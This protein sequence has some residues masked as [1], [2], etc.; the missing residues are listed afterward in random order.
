MFCFLS[1][2]E[3]FTVKSCLQLGFSKVKSFEF[4]AQYCALLAGIGTTLATHAK[5]MM[6]AFE[7]LCLQSGKPWV[8]RMGS[9]PTC[10]RVVDG[11][12]PSLE[13]CPVS[14]LDKWFSCF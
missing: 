13:A 3:D 7:G 4:N 2:I 12:T 6:A 14:P 9:Y 1:R 11:E 8:Q 5:I 10:N